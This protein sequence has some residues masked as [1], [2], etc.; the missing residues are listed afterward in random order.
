MVYFSVIFLTGDIREEIMAF[1][2]VSGD[3]TGQYLSERL[4]LSL[5]RFGLDTW[6]IRRQCYDGAGIVLCINQHD[7]Y[8]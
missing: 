8:Q 6:K 4:L 3:T 7:Y 1:E 2:D 5:Q